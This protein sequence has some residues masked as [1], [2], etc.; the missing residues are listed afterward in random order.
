MAVLKL[1]DKGVSPLNDIPYMLR[2]LADNL[3]AG[4]Y[5]DLKDPEVVVRCVVTIRSSER[6]P[7]VLGFGASASPTQAFEDLHVGAATL[8]DMLRQ[9]QT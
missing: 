3:E 6:V 8:L 5:G 2:S 4:S 9:D 1:A 7:T